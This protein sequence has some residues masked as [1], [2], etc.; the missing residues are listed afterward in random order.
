[1]ADLNAAQLEALG[2]LQTTPPERIYALDPDEW[3]IYSDPDTY[4]ER[5]E[6]LSPA[7][8]MLGV[9]LPESDVAFISIN[10]ACDDN[11]LVIF[12]TGEGTSAVLFGIGAS[13][14]EADD[15]VFMKTIL[16]ITR[17][18]IGVAPSWVALEQTKALFRQTCDNLLSLTFPNGATIQQFIRAC[19]A[20]PEGGGI[21]NVHFMYDETPERLRVELT[22]F[23]PPPG[24]R[25][26]VWEPVTDWE[27]RTH[28]DDVINAILLR[29]ASL[30]FLPFTMV[31]PM[32]ALL[33]ATDEIRVV[34]LP[35]I[36]AAVDSLGLT[37]EEIR[38]ARHGTP[39]SVTRFAQSDRASLLDM[40]AR[41]PQLREKMDDERRA[42]IVESPPDSAD[43]IIMLVHDGD[44]NTVCFDFDD[45]GMLTDVNVVHYEEPRVSLN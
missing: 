24:H 35:F 3:G 19:G 15:A 16:S 36:K 6:I 30:P 8:R 18:P 34:A 26:D 1:M 4:A 43:D 23:P 2:L 45:A 22:A 38:G 27:G 31:F 28:V 7:L 33:P 13:G 14:G 21:F 39:L 29:N 44:P 20:V 12:P 41:A 25:Y 10:E 11:E 32:E 37:P 5:V 40:L 42:R 9:D 17:S